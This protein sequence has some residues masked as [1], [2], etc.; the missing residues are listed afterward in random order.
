MVKSFKKRNTWDLIW[1]LFRT[2]FKLRYNDSVL[3]F[4]WVLL[5]PFSL[6]LIMYFVMSKVFGSTTVDHYAL[7]LL[8]GNIFMTLW[9]EGT[10]L[11]MNS[12]L[13]RAGLITKVNFP[14]Y[15]VLVSATLLAVV[16]FLINICIFFVVAF[17]ANIT[18][19]ITEV[20]W[21]AVC[22]FTLYSLITVVSMFLSIGFVRFRDLQQIWELFGQILFWAT[23]TFYTIDKVANSKLF[24]LVLT[25]INPLSVILISG[26]DALLYGKFQYQGNVLAWLLG[27]LVFGVLGYIYYRNS[28]KKI[29]EYF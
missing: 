4:I 28:I 21:F 6:F 2:D 3:G 24:S 18:P 9:T 27:I 17:F 14:R 23:P 10:N 20:L 8:L 1:Q 13:Y 22:M 12:L 19:T 25:K 29:A 15:I 11:G 5:K 7:Y 26:R 16:N